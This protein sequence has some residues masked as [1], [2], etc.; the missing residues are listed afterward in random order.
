LNRINYF[1]ILT[2]EKPLCIHDEYHTHDLNSKFPLV[3]V[4]W[5]LL[6][7]SCIIASKSATYSFRWH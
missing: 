2:P 7:T 5:L 3:G 1:Q 4:S 6:Q